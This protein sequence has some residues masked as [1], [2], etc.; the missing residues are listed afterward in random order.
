MCTLLYTVTFYSVFW[1]MNNISTLIHVLTLQDRM[2]WYDLCRTLCIHTRCFI[3]IVRL[4]T[5][6]TYIIFTAFYIDT[7]YYR[8][9]NHLAGSTTAGKYILLFPMQYL[10]KRAAWRYISNVLSAIIYETQCSLQVYNTG[11]QAQPSKGDTKHILIVT[12]PLTEG[13]REQG[14]REQG[15][16]E[17]GS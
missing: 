9:C 2:Y 5:W 17:R 13:A 16:R 3:F 10:S 12:R 6:T 8:F 14:A 15:A 7:L 4:R 11:A 1:T